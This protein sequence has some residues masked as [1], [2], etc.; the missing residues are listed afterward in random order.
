MGAVRGGGGGV[1]PS[2][3]PTRENSIYD[4]ESVFLSDCGLN[5]RIKSKSINSKKKVES[6]SSCLNYGSHNHGRFTRN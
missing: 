6:N 5:M 1:V 4:F 2:M 3:C